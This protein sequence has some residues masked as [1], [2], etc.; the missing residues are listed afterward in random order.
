MQRAWHVDARPVVVKAPEGDIFGPQVSAN[1][2]QEEMK[3]HTAPLADLTPAFHTD[4]PCDL[5]FLRQCA[6]LGERPRPPIVTKPDTSRRHCDESER[7][8]ARFEVLGLDT[9]RELIRSLARRL[10]Q[11]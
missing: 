7:S 9:D 3:R 6:Q 1:A 11:R 8:L 5:L 2:S 4:M 10:E